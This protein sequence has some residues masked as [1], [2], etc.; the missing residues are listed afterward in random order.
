MTDA[1]TL[2]NRRR[3]V[4][5]L[6]L[7]AL[8]AGLSACASTAPSALYGIEAPAAAASAGGARKPVQVLV[9][10]P[11][12]LQALDS[13]NIAVAQQGP[14]YSYFPQAAWADQLGNVVQTG[15]VRTLENT[16]RL[17]GVGMPGDGL[18]ID[19]QLQTEIRSFELNIAGSARGVVEIAARLVND[20]NGRTVD[21]QVFR[22]E[23]PSGGQ[24]AE[25]A[26]RAMN[27]AAG[28]VFAELAAWV[29]SKV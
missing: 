5:L 11:K 9:A 14:V 4:T 28:Q 18:L 27:S 12:A 6:G 17:R 21:S 25:Q 1:V 15:L 7:G 24:S 8:A 10:V 23:V 26:V 20:R 19:Y 3:A 13:S 22:A 2:I 29:I 16:G